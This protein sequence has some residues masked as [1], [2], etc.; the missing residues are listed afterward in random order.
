MKSER[1]KPQGNKCSRPEGLLGGL[2]R[3]WLAVLLLLAGF[4]SVAAALSDERVP[5]LISARAARGLFRDRATIQEAPKQPVFH[6]PPETPEQPWQYIVLH[7]SAT[8]RGSVESIHQSHLR[9]KDSSGR[10]W[11]GIGYHFVIG[12]G[13]GMRDGQVRPTFRWQ[14][15]LSGAHAGPALLNQRGIGI[16]LIGNFETGPPTAAQLQSATALVQELSEH[17]LIPQKQI[18]GHSSIRA[19]ACPGKHFPLDELLRSVSR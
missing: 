5:W 16:W 1:Q 11:R 19:T 8:Q 9:R 18:L 15:Q 10:P 6:W 13:Q 17:F 2:R 4:S 7:H 14:E 12:N 3:S